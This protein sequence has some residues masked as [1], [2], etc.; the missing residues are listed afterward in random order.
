MTS[1]S[2]IA[3]PWSSDAVR[4]GAGPTAQS[5]SA[6]APHDAADDVVMVVADPRLVARDGARRLDAPHQ[7]GVGERPQ[8]VVDGLLRD[9]AE[10]LAHEADDRVRVGVRMVVHRG[11]HRDPRTRDA[12]GGPAQHALEFRDRRHAPQCVTD[13]GNDPD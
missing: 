7:A 8:H 10:F 9:L 1:A 2:S 3:K 4:Q 11:E 5:T 13:S 12:Q 6:I